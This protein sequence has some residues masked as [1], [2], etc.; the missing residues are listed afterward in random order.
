[1]ALKE[2]PGRMTVT[3]GTVLGRE[4]RKYQ[5]HDEEGVTLR[6]MGRRTVS[7]HPATVT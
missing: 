4:A 6:S 2:S 3:D 7:R 1:M 5:K